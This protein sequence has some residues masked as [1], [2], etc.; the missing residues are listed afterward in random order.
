MKSLITQNSKI[1]KASVKTYNFGIPAGKGRSGKL[2]C[3]FAGDCFSF[4]YAKKGMYL[5]P[6]AKD[7]YETRLAATKK[8]DFVDVITQEISKKKKIEFFRINDSGDFYSPEYLKKWAD[9][10]AKNEHII[11]YAYTKSVSMV[12][13]FKALNPVLAQN[14]VFIYSFGGKQDALIDVSKDRHAKIFN[15]KAEL[16]AAGY[17]DASENDSVA[18][19][20]KTG[21]IGLVIH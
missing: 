13:M 10:A 16:K 1:K 20:S 12:K 18:V 4:C 7:A 8:N 19:L 17:D 5:F 21:R 2:T 15:S 6:V 9:I 14:M 11:F 3:P